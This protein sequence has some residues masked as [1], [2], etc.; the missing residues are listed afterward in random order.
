MSHWVWVEDNK[1]LQVFIENQVYSKREKF[2][3]FQFSSA[4]F[5]KLISYGFSVLKFFLFKF[6]LSQNSLSFIH[7]LLYEKL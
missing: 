4:I 7:I 6:L 5:P 1:F 2:F 3:S